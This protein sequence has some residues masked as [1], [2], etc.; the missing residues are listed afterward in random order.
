MLVANVLNNFIYKTTSKD[1]YEL[2]LKKNH[3]LYTSKEHKQDTVAYSESFSLATDNF[4]VICVS[5]K[6]RECINF[7]RNVKPNSNCHKL[8]PEEFS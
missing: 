5:S 7:S 1:E 4:P 2:P 6:Y 8:H 3:Q